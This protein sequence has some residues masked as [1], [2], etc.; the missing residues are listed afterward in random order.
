VSDTPSVD[1]LSPRENALLAVETDPLS[2]PSVRDVVPTAVHSWVAID[3]V[4][5]AANPPEPPTIGGMLYPGKRILFSGETESLKTWLA[6]ILAKAEL[7]AGYPVAWA[8]LDAM[9]EGEILAR[10]R[11]L[12]VPDEQISRQFLYY[13]PDDSLTG[14]ALEDVRVEIADRQIRLFVIDAFNAALS[15]HGLDPSSTPDVETFWREVAQPLC[16]AG[17]AVTLLDHVVKNPDGRGK[18][19]YGSERKASGAH[20]HIGFR[21]LEAFTRGGSGR[22]VLATQKDRAGFLPRPTIGILELTSAADSVSYSLTADRSRAGDKFRPT[23]LMERVSEYLASQDEPASK[24]RIEDNIS[25]KAEAVRTA[26]SVLLEEG[27]ARQT[28]GKHGAQLIEFVRFYRESDDDFQGDESTSSPPRP[29]LV[30]SLLSTP[31]SDL[32]PSSPSKGDEDEVEGRPRPSTSSRPVLNEADEVALLGGCEHLEQWRAKDGVWRCRRCE[33]PA[34]PGEV[35]EERVV[36]TEP[37]DDPDGDINFGS[38]E[39]A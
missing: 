12:G 22:T 19:A 13:A 37:V 38:V 35:V 5:A 6:L 30:P 21:P 32:V 23:Y 1:H 17:A 28:E 25:G 9:G 33:P 4:A 16:D 15:M 24:K 18:Y 14:Q 29:H 31:P 3:I 39:A 26:I 2:Q 20:V 7:D 8:D 11:L 34:F 36:S 27:Y 10:L